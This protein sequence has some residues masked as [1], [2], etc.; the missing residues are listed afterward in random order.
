MSTLLHLVDIKFNLMQQY[1]NWKHQLLKSFNNTEV[2]FTG[3]LDNKNLFQ[4]K[5]K[6]FSNIIQKNIENGFYFPSINLKNSEFYYLGKHFISSSFSDNLDILTKKNLNKLS[7]KKLKKEIDI[8][9][10]NYINTS[11][12]VPETYYSLNLIRYLPLVNNSV[13]SLD[14]SNVTFFEDKDGSIIDLID[15]GIFDLVVNIEN[16]SNISYYYFDSSSSLNI[17]PEFLKDDT[18]ISSVYSKGYEKYKNKSMVN[19]VAEYVDTLTGRNLF[20]FDFINTYLNSDINFDNKLSCDSIS[21]ETFLVNS[22]ISDISSDDYLYTYLFTHLNDQLNASVKSKLRNRYN[23][24][25]AY[26]EEVKLLKEIDL[27]NK[28]AEAKII[29]DFDN[30][31]IGER[32][33]QRLLLALYNKQKNEELKR[34]E[35]KKKSQIPEIKIENYSNLDSSLDDLNDVF[36]RKH[37]F[38]TTSSKEVHTHDVY[39][40]EYENLGNL[41]VPKNIFFS[42]IDGDNIDVAHLDYLNKINYYESNLNIRNRRRKIKL[43]KQNKFISDQQRSVRLMNCLNDLLNYSESHNFDIEKPSNLSAELHLSK[44]YKFF[45]SL[46]TSY[47]SNNKF[48]I[49]YIP[50]LSN[51]KTKSQLGNQITRNVINMY[52]K[53]NIHVQ[54]IAPS[55][56]GLFYYPN[57]N[58]QDNK[59]NYYMYWD[60]N[61]LYYKFVGLLIRHGK[62]HKA[63]YILNNSFLFIKNLSLCNPL[64][65]F[66]KALYNGQTFFEFTKQKKQTKSLLIPRYTPLN[67]R[68]KISMRTIAQNIRNGDTLR[69]VMKAKKHKVNT[70]YLLSNILI[71]YFFKIGK[72]KND[73]ITNVTNAYK[74]KHLLK[75]NTGTFVYNRLLKFLAFRKIRGYHISK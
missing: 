67:K 48:P 42:D 23:N 8:D 65:I 14:Y 35:E 6:Y 12:Y 19:R 22:D 4:Y 61:C 58:L 60:I 37:K 75:K 25:I 59:F 20:L 44:Q 56:K 11:S 43:I 47:K 17:E 51:S 13:H 45:K 64:Y 1:L 66:M 39:Q 29:D 63:E 33:K 72:V 2:F 15:F 68:I 31:R 55:I 3:D 40:H 27:K 52:R 53:K 34:D 16:T 7:I 46:F 30:H 36:L 74:Q 41:S 69:K 73:L 21:Y 26:I 62:R 50:H 57:V 28:A 54:L 38:F 70:S 71:S 9:Q 24:T 5:Y 49:L 18:V 32:K 10:S